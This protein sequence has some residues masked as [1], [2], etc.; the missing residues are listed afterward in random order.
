MLGGTLRGSK[1]VPLAVGGGTVAVTL[2]LAKAARCTLTLP[3]TDR[4]VIARQPRRN[5]FSLAADVKNGRYTLEL[6]CRD[7]Q[8]RRYTLS[9]T[10]PAPVA[11]R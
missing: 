2:R 10:A 5:V 3:L 6:A 9:I 7:K 8:P 11:A 1:R 4:V